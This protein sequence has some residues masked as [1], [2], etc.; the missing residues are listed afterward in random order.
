MAELQ[1][2]ARGQVKE[3]YKQKVS[4]VALSETKILNAQSQ[5]QRMREGGGVLL[6]PAPSICP[7]K[8]PQR[9]LSC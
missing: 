5:I 7:A 9:K 2:K 1:D 8:V 4:K 6:F 3:E